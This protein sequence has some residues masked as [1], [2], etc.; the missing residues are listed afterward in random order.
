MDSKLHT[1]N[2]EVIQFLLSVV[3]NQ[4]QA[5]V[6][7]APGRPR[8]FTLILWPMNR[9]FPS[10]GGLALHT[11]LDSVQPG[12]LT[13]WTKA[14]P[15]SGSKIG[16]K[17]YGLG[18][19]DVKCDSLCKISALLKFSNHKS[20]LRTPYFVGSFSEEIGMLGAK[21]IAEKKLVQPEFALVGE[22]SDGHLSY[23]N[24]GFVWNEGRIPLTFETYA[25]PRKEKKFSGRSA[26]SSAPHKA[27]NGLYKFFRFLEKNPRFPVGAISGT[28]GPNTI[29]GAIL[30]QSGQTIV[31]PQAIRKLLKIWKDYSRWQLTL[32][33]QGHQKIFNPNSATSSWTRLE[34]RKT[35]M[36][37]GFDLRVLPGQSS[38]RLLE[39]LINRHPEIA[40][41][42]ESPAFF[43]SPQQRLG[44]SLQKIMGR[45]RKFITK[46]GSNEAYFYQLLGAEA[47][48][49]APG[50]SY[51]NIHSP[52]EN[53]EIDSIIEAERFYTEVIK[54]LC[55]L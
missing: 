51:G 39:P 8:D 37:F 17:I 50:Q 43:Q 35:E 19:A 54:S 40:T 52:N 26:H 42:R 16:G 29:P 30:V 48:V 49:H 9:P 41:I 25:G 7:P 32:P 6:I 22:P 53:I 38:T 27:I 46:S 11:H 45:K 21:F 15:Y 12:E 31:A 36:Y 3:K 1:G 2:N 33:K 13:L 14:K 47:F 18:A 28:I 24:K 5:K 23:A 34:V 10:T 4:L 20:F 44:K 55:L